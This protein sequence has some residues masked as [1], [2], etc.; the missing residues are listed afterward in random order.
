MARILLLSSYEPPP[1]GIAKHS[2]QLVEAWDAAGHNVL[3][4]APGKQSSL[5][6]AERVGSNARVARV[7]RL[8]PRRR[9]WSDIVG[10]QPDV[11]VVQ[12]AIA[13]LSVNLWSV[14]KLCERLC[15]AGVPVVVTY[16]EPEREYNLL[17][18]ITRLIYRMMVRVTD[19]P[20]AFSPSGREALVRRG[21]FKSVVEVPLGTMGVTEITDGEFA[22][23]R[24]RYSIRKPL[25]LTLGFTTID[26]GVDVLLDAA[27]DIA[28]MRSNDVQ[29]LIAGKPRKRRGFFRIMERPDV[30]YQ[31]RLETQARQLENLDIAFSD[32][33]A[34]EDVAALLH[35]ADVVVLPYRRITQSGVANLT[36]SSGCVVVCSDLPGLRSDL[37]DSAK[38]VP[39]GD[40]KAL[41]EQ[42][43]SL[44]AEDARGI[45][46]Q[47]RELSAKRASENTFA[48]V[49]ERILT[50]GLAHRESETTPS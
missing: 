32:F 26:K 10:F 30:N 43:A 8:I 25:V 18:P 2:S 6:E 3:V 17:G 42:V 7:L 15:A 34:Y 14:R 36:L 27:S 39:V 49:A 13:A 29:F 50:A 28:Q 16:H 22:R 33:V 35:T 21:L 19:V 4:I 5:I 37:G 11:V 31:R 44:L 12:F 48:R 23:V 38:Y 1:D 40:F 47:M 45:R 9:T 46:S 24:E 20:I 41:A